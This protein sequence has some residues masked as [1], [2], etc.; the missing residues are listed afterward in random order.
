MGSAAQSS[1]HQPL[2]GHSKLPSFLA[3]DME[4]VGSRV[5]GT[6]ASI[7]EEFKDFLD[8]GNVIDLAIGII[9]GAA[10]TRV[11]N[12]FVEDIL[13]PPIG[14]LLGA[15]NFENQFVVLKYGPSKGKKATKSSPAFDFLTGG[16]GGG[17]HSDTPIGP[18]PPPSTPYHPVYHTVEQAQEAGAVTLNYG[19]FIQLTANFL[20]VAL[21]LYGLIRLV[22]LFRR[23]RTLFKTDK[24]RYC[25]KSISIKAKRCPFCTSMLTSEPSGPCDGNNSGGDMSPSQ[26]HKNSATA[27]ASSS[28]SPG[29]HP[30]SPGE[31]AGISY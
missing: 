18:G 4:R 7:W 31:P 20:V 16:N 2:M 26:Q 19:R 6:V 8:Q 28:V 13:L 12:S 15:A 25:R 29:K 10:F 22:L 27:V 11:V 3:V 23:N 5:S 1:E 30:A 9:I 24:C 14:L 17:G 21:V